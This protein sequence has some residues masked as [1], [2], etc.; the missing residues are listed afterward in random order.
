MDEGVTGMVIN[1]MPYITSDSS[2][3]IKLSIAYST[4]A[5]ATDG[6]VNIWVKDEPPTGGEYISALIE[7]GSVSVENT[8]HSNSESDYILGGGV[9][10]GAIYYAK[11]AG[12]IGIS[13]IYKLDLSNFEVEIFSDL[14]NYTETGRGYVRGNKFYFINYDSSQGRGLV[15]VDLDTK[16]ISY[17]L[18]NP[19]IGNKSYYHCFGI[20]Q[21]ATKIHLLRMVNGGSGTA[22]NTRVYELSLTDLSDTYLFYQDPVRYCFSD[23]YDDDNILYAITEDGNPYEPFFYVID[24]DNKKMVQAS[25]QYARAA[26]KVGDVVYLIAGQQ[27]CSI[28]KVNYDGTQVTLDLVIEDAFSKSY[29]YSYAETTVSKNYSGYAVEGNT[30][31][32]YAT[33]SEDDNTNAP[34]IKITLNAEEYNDDSIIISTTTKQKNLATII[35]TDELEIKQFI[36]KV[37]RKNADGSVTE[38]EAYTL[39]SDG[40][41]LRV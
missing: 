21:S 35:K 32:L 26:F 30:L 17:V 19:F 2:A 36:N 31:W 13:R 18:G 11:A 15:I 23:M 10:N 24:I 29:F 33:P 37:Y 22:L 6:S 1:N 38:V 20:N 5:P 27:T 9:Y 41:W 25:I 12:G 8:Q 7:Y 28:Y 39:S 3:N 14:S 16:D 34:I 4:I 40:T